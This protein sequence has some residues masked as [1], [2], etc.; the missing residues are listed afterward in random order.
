MV[1]KARAKHGLAK[2][3]L[4]AKLIAAA[5][6]HSAE[7]GE[8]KYFDHDSRIR[9]AKSGRRASS[10]SATRMKGYRYWRAGENID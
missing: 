7:M 6:S 1:N 4:N 5:R 9:R 10:V 3:R 2:L 8:L